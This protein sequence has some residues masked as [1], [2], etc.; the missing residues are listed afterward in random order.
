MKFIRFIIL[1]FNC[2]YGNVIFII[3]HFTTSNET[4]KNEEKRRKTKK[5][6][7]KRRKINR[8]FS[9]T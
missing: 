9:T 4:K 2:L 6:E 1:Q 3:H 7:E 5:N 8:C